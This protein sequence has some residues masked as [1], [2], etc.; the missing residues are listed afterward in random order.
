VVLLITGLSLLGRGLAE[1]ELFSGVLF[2]I[3]IMSM[4]IERFAIAASEQGHRAALTRLGWTAI[5]SVLAYPIF[6]GGWWEQVMF[7]YPELVLC[8]MGVL[9]WIGSYTGFRAVELVRFRSLAY[10][11]PSDVRP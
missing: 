9:V 3:V 5:A 7:G 4:L 11:S 1:R 2:P 10:G 8:I 6:R